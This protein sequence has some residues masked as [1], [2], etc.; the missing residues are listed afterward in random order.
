[1]NRII[2]FIAILTISTTHASLG[3]FLSRGTILYEV[4]T[5]MKKTLGNTPWAEGMKDKLPAFKSSF[6]KLSFDGNRAQ[7]VFDHYDDKDKIPEF[8]RQN[9]EKS[10][11]DHDFEKSIYLSNKELFGTLFSIR[12]SIFKIKWRLSNENRIISGYN[13]RKATGIIM[14]SVYVFAFYTDEI[15]TPGGPA[16]IHGLPGMIL[17][18]TIPRLY[19]SFMA[20]EIKGMENSPVF[21]KLEESIKVY[22]RKSAIEAVKK[23]TSDWGSDEDSKSF[24]DQ[25]YWNLLL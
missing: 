17:G 24:M 6:F 7:Y 4:K 5:N 14:D 13:C 20:V 15:T 1:M 11:W 25:I 22:D 2:G 10:A 23:N 8:L 12:D 18:L 21:Q 16:T 3:Q 9:D 19:T